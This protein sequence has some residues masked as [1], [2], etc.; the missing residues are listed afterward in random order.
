MDQEEVCIAELV[1]AANNQSLNWN[2]FSA[3][4]SNFERKAGA[5]S[6]LL[7]RPHFTRLAHLY[8]VADS[9]ADRAQ[10]KYKRLNFLV[11]ALRFHGHSVWHGPVVS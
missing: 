3:N 1:R 5:L 7:S 11:V 10:E 4:I 2:S 8:D 6:R 9:A